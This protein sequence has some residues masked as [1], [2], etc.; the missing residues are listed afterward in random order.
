[1]RILYIAT[2]LIVSFATP[3]LAA[4]CPKDVKRIDEAIQSTAGLSSSQMT[5]IKT[6]RD[7]GEMLHKSG[8]HGESLTALHKALTILGIEPH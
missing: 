7:E 8:S 1:M 4:H 2:A 6:L 3:A 5:E